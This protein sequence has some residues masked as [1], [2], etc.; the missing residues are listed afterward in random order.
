MRSAPACCTIGPA[1][2]SSFTR[3]RSVVMFCCTAESWMAFWVSG[4]SVSTRKKS[5]PSS[6]AFTVTPW[7]SRSITAS[8]F[9]RDSLSRNRTCTDWPSRVTPP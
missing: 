5:V 6:R 3:L 1:T 8:A 7:M 4:R 9:A 2:P